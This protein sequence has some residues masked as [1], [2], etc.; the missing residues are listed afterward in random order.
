VG[1]AWLAVLCREARG[2]CFAAIGLYAAAAAGVA[3]F[4]V[5]RLLCCALAWPLLFAS[6]VSLLKTGWEAP[7]W[8][9]SEA[10]AGQCAAAATSIGLLALLRSCRGVA[11]A[12]V[13][14]VG[15]LCFVLWFK[16]EH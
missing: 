8:R 2:C 3:A 16:N 1:R 9:G 14:V 7:R 6:P 10:A 11:V 12:V 13:A 4:V 5:L 15:R